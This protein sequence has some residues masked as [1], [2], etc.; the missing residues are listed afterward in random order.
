ML[1]APYQILAS[2][3]CACFYE[4]PQRAFSR[5]SHVGHTNEMINQAYFHPVG[6]IFVKYIIQKNQTFPFPIFFLTSLPS[7][8]AKR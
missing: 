5:K 4:A 3:R 8:M 7:L 1:Y 6:K 2:K